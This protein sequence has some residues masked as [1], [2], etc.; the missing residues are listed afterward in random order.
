MKKESSFLYRNSLSLVLI[1]CFGI[2]F[3]GQVYN[4]IKVYEDEMNELGSP[5][6][7][8][9]GE[10]LQTGHFFQTT[11]E[12]WESEFLQM[13]MYVLFTVF[14]RQIGSSE[15]KSIEGEEEV[16]RQPN[17]RRKNVPWPV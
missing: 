14:L 16:D 10:Y 2:C 4:G 5:R 11:F 3:L 15:S 17:P 1:L 6:D 12:N 13:G 9:I 8:S 7:V